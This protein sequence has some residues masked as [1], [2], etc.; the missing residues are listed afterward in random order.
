MIHRKSKWCL[1]YLIEIA[2]ELN[3]KNP[4]NAEKGNILEK[5]NQNEWKQEII[6]VYFKIFS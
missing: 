2:E 3:K 6:F 5:S 4:E 1:A